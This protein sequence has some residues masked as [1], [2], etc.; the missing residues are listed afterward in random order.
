[1]MT[2]CV[3]TLW[4]LDFLRYCLHLIRPKWKLGLLVSI[5]LL[6]SLL[7]AKWRRSALKFASEQVK[8]P[9]EMTGNRG[10][11]K[12]LEQELSRK[13][14]SVDY[15][16]HFVGTLASKVRETLSEQY[17]AHV[18]ERRTLLRTDFSAYQD[19]V[20]AWIQ[21]IDLAI[22]HQAQAI[23]H[24]DG[25]EWS[26]LEPALGKFMLFSRFKLSVPILRLALDPPVSLR[27]LSLSSCE[28]IRDFVGRL[29]RQALPIREKVSGPVRA[30][31]VDAV[32]EDEVWLTFNIELYEATETKRPFPYI[33]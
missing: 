26:R 24:Q 19:C 23:A 7:R 32:V 28:E 18:K 20:S 21:H 17:Q 13:V 14:V 4:L 29:R 31:I 10:K 1:M 5:C 9:D 3:F 15:I 2:V 30:K 27:K 16:Q 8:L 25:I 22:D 33:C 6:L 12:A 11:F